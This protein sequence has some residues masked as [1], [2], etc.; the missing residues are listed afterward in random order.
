MTTGNNDFEDTQNTVGD[1]GDNEF[2]KEQCC[3][4][5]CCGNKY[6]RD[7][8][9]AFAELTDSVENL[10]R[11]LVAKTKAEYRAAFS[12][13]Q[14]RKFAECRNNAKSEVA[15]LAD[16][17]SAWLQSDSGVGSNCNQDRNKPC[18]RNE[19]TPCEKKSEESWSGPNI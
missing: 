15:S 17:F 8:Y 1:D 2:R 6:D 7:I 11:K 16:R 5:K 4:N 3:N 19:G 10:G 14:R 9:E 18:C 12:V 13:E